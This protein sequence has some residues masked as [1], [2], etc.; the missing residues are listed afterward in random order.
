MMFAYSL[1]LGQGTSNMAKARALLYGLK[2]CVIKG[3]DRIWGETDSLL[4]FKCING[5]WRTPWR[6][7]KLIHEAQEIVE[8]HGFIISHCFREANKLVD[9]LASKSYSVDAIHDSTLSLI[10]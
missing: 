5:E 3:Y 7:D 10:S 9:K 2:W 8:S 6:L 1:G 4:L